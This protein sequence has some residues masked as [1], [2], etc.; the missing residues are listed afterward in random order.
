MSL[1]AYTL[2]DLEA[3]TMDSDTV[4][5][6]DHTH[7]EIP[8]DIQPK[9]LNYI[10]EPDKISLSFSRLQ[11]LRTCP[12]KFLCRELLGQGSYE[13][14]IHTAYG[15]SFAAGVQELFRSGSLARAFLAVLEAWDYNYFTDPWGKQSS[16]SIYYAIAS[17]QQWYYSVFSQLQTEYVIAQLQGKPAVELFVY[18]AVGDS[19]NYQIHIDLVLEHIETGNLTVCEIKT[20][21]MPQQRANWENS[22]QTLGYYTEI[23][24]IAAM[25]NR[26]I[27]PEI[28]YIVQQ[29]GKLGDSAANHGFYTFLFAKDSS[30]PAEF[31]LDLATQTA[32]L[33]TYLE[34][35]YFPKYG[36]NCVT[37]GRPCQ[38]F[39]L[40]DDIAAL[41]RS[42]SS[43][44]HYEHNNLTSADY[45]LSFESVVYLLEDTS[46]NVIL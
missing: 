35:D 11:T 24:A 29:T 45:V 41:P 6:P 2:A 5:V 27:S 7:G 40:C 34:N 14:T 39:G 18:L 36:H 22:I 3:D 23:A 13:P 20:S 8:L 43:A 30:A 32:I 28:M 44:Q 15:H 1:M 42:A 25:E 33:E 37:F 26:T 9:K 10:F 4:Y 12:R 17:V 31:M 16:K 19:Y 38:Y 21:G 46:D